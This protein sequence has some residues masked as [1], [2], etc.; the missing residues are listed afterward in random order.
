MKTIC[1]DYDVALL[2][3]NHADVLHEPYLG[4]RLPGRAWRGGA[5]KRARRKAPRHF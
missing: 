2:E 5:Q 4:R 1:L 3:V